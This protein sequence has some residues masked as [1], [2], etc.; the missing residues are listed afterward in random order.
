MTRPRLSWWCL[1]GAAWGRSFGPAGPRDHIGIGRLCRRCE[2]CLPVPGVIAEL[3]GD[4]AACH[5]ESVSGPEGAAAPCIVAALYT[6]TVGSLCRCTVTMG[7]VLKAVG[8][9][10]DLLQ[11]IIYFMSVGVDPNVNRDG[12]LSP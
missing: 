9:D 12:L 7:R 6:F 5:G 10:E 2:A 1:S 3:A 11:L 8:I 4:G